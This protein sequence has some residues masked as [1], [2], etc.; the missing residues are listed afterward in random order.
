MVVSAIAYRCICSKSTAKSLLKV[1][2]TA[3]PGGPPDYPPGPFFETT[4]PRPT[5]AVSVKL[6]AICTSLPTPPSVGR[7][8]Y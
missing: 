2:M 8:Q 4:A 3:R 5:P 7:L 1:E 6:S